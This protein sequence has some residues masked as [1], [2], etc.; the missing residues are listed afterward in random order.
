MSD[1]HL[2]RAAQAAE[3]ALAQ[4]SGD[5]YDCMVAALGRADQ[6]D[7]AGAQAL[8]D[9][10]VALEPNDPAVLTG[11]AN[12]YRKEGRLSEAVRA[13]DAA[14]AAA[15]QYPDAWIERG[16]AYAA[17]GSSAI[18][19]DSYARAAALAPGNAVAHAGFAALAARDGALD[20]AR[21]AA[22]R[23]LRLDPAS[24]VAAGTLATVALEEG[25]PD[26]ARRVLEPALGRTASGP[27][28]PQALTLLATA[29]ERLGDPDAAYPLYARA[30]AEFAA[31]HER[32]VAGSL[33]GLRL[34]EAI[35]A[36]LRAVDPRLW[37]RPSTDAR[38]GDAIGPVFLTGYPRSGTTLVEN[39]LASL[40]GVAALEERPTL[41]AADRRYLSG[42]EAAIAAGLAAFARLPESGLA[43][44]RTAYWDKVHAAGVPAKTPH[45]V[46]MDP[47]KGAHLPFIA[48]MFP[49]ARVVIM[50][51]DPRDVVWSCFKT[52][53]APTTGTLEFTTLERAARHYDALMRLIDLALERLPLAVFELDY[54]RVV[55]EFEPTTRALCAFT[56]IPW[57]EDVRR[58]DK[59]AQARG[60]ST[61]SA[62]QV[63]KGLYDGSGQW[64]PYARH[65][66]PIVPILA[67]WIERFGHA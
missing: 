3:A 47:L 59:T 35:E 30:N 7:R 38:A 11:L 22:T 61:A 24:L 4:G 57:S 44:L 14:I 10:A 67:P 66:E 55:R 32:E 34:I 64:R 51:R 43:E 58:F 8:F 19:R 28:R 53:F 5:A 20:E 63:R 26:A 31:L 60:V 40:P 52:P 2:A 17:G 37:R 23:A 62:G 21:H 46:D 65:F 15:P 1:P 9:R 29:H 16:A 50:R 25:E 45:F 33:S 12:W 18:A 42:D 39:V 41:G 49:E 13:C 36:G 48:R 6:G 56:G 27:D 54:H